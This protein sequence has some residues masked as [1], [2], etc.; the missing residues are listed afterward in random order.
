MCERPIKGT[1]FIKKNIWGIGG[2]VALTSETEVQ[3]KIYKSHRAL[4]VYMLVKPVEQKWC[5]RTLRM[6][7]QSRLPPCSTGYSG[8]RHF[9][10]CAN[11]KRRSLSFASTRRCST[12]C[13]SRKRHS[14]MCASRRRRSG[15]CT[16]RSRR[17]AS[18]DHRACSSAKCGHER[19][20]LSTV[21]VESAFAKRRLVYL[22]TIS[23]GSR[24][25]WIAYTWNDL[26][27]LANS[28]QLPN[29]LYNRKNV[30]ELVHLFSKLKPK[31]LI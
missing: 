20:R 29:F 1:R 16:S 27:R 18:G 5:G 12:M 17:S 3:Y 22:W 28:M 26:L 14:A 4:A 9:A 25:C 6:P 21:L 24:I 13:T 7:V 15:W 31:E 2:L 19:R 23:R 10:R 30:T 8:R 11:R